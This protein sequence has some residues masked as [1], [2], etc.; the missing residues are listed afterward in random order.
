MRTSARARLP[1]IAPCE[2]P[3]TVCCAKIVL[4]RLP[5]T[6]KTQ[7]AARNSSTGSEAPVVTAVLRLVSANATISVAEVAA[8]HRLVP[9]QVAARPAERDA[10]DLEH[11]RRPCELERDVGVLLDDEDGE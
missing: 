5:T 9:L 10:P 6:G 3:A 2:R 8:A 1:K 11:V 4:A 7:A